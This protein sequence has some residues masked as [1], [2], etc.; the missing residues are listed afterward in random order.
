MKTAMM[1]LLLG[2]AAAGCASPSRIRQAG[3]AHLD[4]ARTLEARGDYDRAARERA[5]ADKQFRKAQARAYDE[6]R[7]GVYRY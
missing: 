4:K 7:M 6:A 2:A 1:C 5:A 3:Y